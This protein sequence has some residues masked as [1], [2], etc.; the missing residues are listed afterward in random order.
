MEEV[1][2]VTRDENGKRT[3]HYLRWDNVCNYI[4]EHDFADEDEILLVIVEGTCIYSGLRNIL[5]PCDQITWT[6]LQGFFA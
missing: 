2:I 1:I 6:E 4:D 3:E 5:E